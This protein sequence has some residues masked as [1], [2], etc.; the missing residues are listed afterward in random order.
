MNENNK[1][2]AGEAK[3][4]EYADRILAGEPE[5][6]VTNGL[7]EGFRNSVKEQLERKKEENGKSKD[8]VE[9]IVPPQ[10]EGLDSETVDFIWDIPIYLNP[11]KT[12]REKM[13]KEKCLEFLK[14]KEERKNK[15]INIKKEEE[16]KIN[17]VRKDLGLSQAI[18][19]QDNSA[20]VPV[21]PME[22]RKKVTVGWESSYVLAEV[23]KTQGIDLSKLSREAY[24]A[25]AIQQGLAIDDS[26][27]RANPV[28]RMA[29]SP[30]EAR[31]M[32]R[33]ED[34]KITKETNDNFSR[35]CFEMKEKAGLTDQKDRFISAGVRVR[36]GTS[37]S[38]SWLFFG[39]NKDLEAKQ[40]ETYKGYICFEDINKFTPARFKDFMKALQEAGFNG[41]VKSF[42]DIGFQASRL[43]DQLVMHGRTKE[44]SILAMQ[45]AEKFFGDEIQSKSFGKDEVVDGGNLSYSQVLAKKIK[46][47]IK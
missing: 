41:G 31:D 1:I 14:K 25:Y 2:S 9:I 35:F 32:M 36:S 8:F 39:I 28:Q 23:A 5:E 13:R 7:P 26:Q 34:K 42:Q 22:E 12:N 10:Y 44:D 43:N 45:I 29:T 40:L 16:I 47:K 21:M 4:L 18:A 24:V 27:L 20:I 19:T 46:D 17:I 37:S 38:D 33:V 6:S 30:E 11:E 15:N 3:A